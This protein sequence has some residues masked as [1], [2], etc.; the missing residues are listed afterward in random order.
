MAHNPAPHILLTRPAEQSAAYK[1]VLEAEFG[2]RLTIIVSPLLEIRYLATTLRLE[3]VAHLLFTSM[4]G[5]AAFARLSK[6]R[7]IPALCVGARTA[8][9]AQMAGLDARSANGSVDDLI[10]LAKS[11]AGPFL[12]PR[13]V[14]MARDIAAELRAGGQ[15]VDEAIAYDQRPL[16]LTKQAEA[17]L[18]DD[19]PCLV[20][21]FSPR[22]ARLFM[23]ECQALAQ[24]RVIAICISQ[25]VADQLEPAH[26]E[27]FVVADNPTANAVTREIAA[28]L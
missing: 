7:D 24:H 25:N 17:V 15:Q 10:G 1:S 2:T 20:A 22:S 11:C 23:D 6:R 26:F 4:N 13:G 28:A 27:T 12:Y 5:V 21:L 8:K 19:A 16:G 9:A 3:G 18:T 14:H